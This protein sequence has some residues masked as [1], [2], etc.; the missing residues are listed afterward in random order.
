MCSSDLGP[1]GNYEK[2]YDEGTKELA[3]RIA[4]SSKDSIIGGGDTVSIVSKLNLLDRFTFVST[5]GGAMLDFLAD[6]SLPG[7]KA[8]D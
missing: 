8:L 2:G 7:I 1:L 6:E 4:E 5:A 3:H